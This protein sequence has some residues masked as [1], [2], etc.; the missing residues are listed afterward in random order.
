VEDVI[1]SSGLGFF[2]LDPN[3]RLRWSNQGIPNASGLTDGDEIVFGNSRIFGAVHFLRSGPWHTSY[4]FN[5]KGSQLWFAGFLPRYL[6]PT[7]PPRMLPGGRLAY[8]AG[9]GS[10]A[11][12]NQD[13]FADWIVPHPDGAQKLLTPAVGSDGSIYTGDAFGVQLWS[14]NSDGSTRWVLGGDVYDSLACLGVSPDNRVVVAG[15]SSYYGGGWIRGFAASNGALLWQLDLQPE[16]GLTQIVRSVRPAFSA[17]GDTAYLTTYFAGSGVGHAYLYAI[18]LGEVAG[19]RLSRLTLNPT[20]VRGGS[21]AIGTVTLTGAATE[22]TVVTL[23]SNS[24]SASV[25]GTVAIP[26]GS[27]QAT[28]TVSTYPVTSN[29]NATISASRLGQTVTAR[30]RITRN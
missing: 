2:S 27:S 22:Y 28:F 14:A 16:Q 1:N 15:G 6:E 13:G 11:A 9:A 21:S 4:G 29:T 8:R 25:P 26:A 30:L 23:S 24:V 12:V 20:S 3:G 5:H 10:L 18:N 19:P 17:N 7:S